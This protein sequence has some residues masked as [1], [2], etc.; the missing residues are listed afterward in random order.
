MNISGKYFLLIQHD[1]TNAK[2]TKYMSIPIAHIPRMLM[3]MAS[4]V[5]FIIFSIIPP[6]F[7]PNQN[8]N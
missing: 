6:L 1:S 8:N 4:F 5:F 3:K 2:K 7:L